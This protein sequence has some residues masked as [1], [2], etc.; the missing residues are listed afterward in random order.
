MIDGRILFIVN[1]TAGGG[2]C[3]EA[4]RQACVILNNKNIKYDTKISKYSG[5]AI[6]L[7]DEAAN[8]GYDVIVA[9]GGDGTVNEI[10][11]VLCQKQRIRFGIFPFGTGN[12]IAGTLGIPS[13]P[14]DAVDLL[15]NGTEHSMDMGIATELCGEKRSRK[16]INIAGIGFDVDVLMK[17]NKHKKHSSGMLPYIFGIIDALFNRKRLHVRIICDKIKQDMDIIIALVANGKRFGGG[18]MATPNAEVDDNLFDVCIIES[19]N[20]LQLIALLPSFI[21]GKHLK[22]KQIR[23]FKTDRIRIESAEQYDIET[24]G[25][26][27]LKTSVEYRI[28]PNAL[29]IIRY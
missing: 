20:T 21:K 15:I 8:E 26:I 1:P 17:T 2:R 11:S 19:V 24:D 16:F 25:E 22:F 5:H 18:M 7:A 10:S 6:K 14:S 27:N 9:V 12:D 29:K 28:I 13:N 23:Y 4:F 3:E